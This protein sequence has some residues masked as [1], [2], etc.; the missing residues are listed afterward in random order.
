[1]AT[2]NEAERTRQALRRRRRLRQILGAVV[3]VLV[4][5]GLYSVIS[6][7]VRLAAQLFDDT[8]EREEFE[9]RLQT[10][11]SLDPEPFDSLETANRARLLDAAIWSVIQKNSDNMD[12][13]ERDEIGAMYLPT[14]DVD[15]ELSSLYGPD[16]QFNH[17]T[18]TD[19]GL[20]YTYVPE[21][22]AYLLPIT[23]A[24]GVYLPRVMDIR[25]ENGG[26]RVTVGYLDIY[27]G[28]EIVFDI[29]K[30]EPV[31][32]QDYIFMR[33][34]GVYYLTAIQQS[35]MSN[36]TNNA[37]VAAP[38]TAATPQ[39][40]VMS[41]VATALPDTPDDGQNAADGTEPA[42]EGEGT[43]EDAAPAEDGASAEDGTPEDADAPV[44][45][46]DAG[47]GE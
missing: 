34:G 8:E 19:N 46:A 15:K 11:V 24:N 42:P 2:A 10:L 47:N 6:S 40:D 20:T 35:E 41:Q 5:I 13:Y 7:G 22:S 43:A 26:K 31:K 17:E 18:F 38:Q 16:F 27:G 21:K 9:Q 25:R 4:L 1:M 45:D 23:S 12:V 28:G 39:G 37:A 29:T 14:L 30:L 36:A 32:Y 3:C 33:S 44:D